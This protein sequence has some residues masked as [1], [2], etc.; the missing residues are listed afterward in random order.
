MASLGTFGCI[1]ALRGNCLYG[2]HSR[3]LDSSSVETVQQQSFRNWKRVLFGFVVFMLPFLVQREL[4]ALRYNC[5]IGFASIAVLSAALCYRAWESTEIA[6]ATTTLVAGPV[7]SLNTRLEGLMFAFPI[8]ILSFLSHFNILPIQAA[9][10][11]PS[12][13]RIQ[14]VVTTAVLA[15]GLLMYVFGVSGYLCFRSKIEGNILI[16]LKNENDVIVLAG[17]FGCGVTILF[18]MPLMVLPCRRNIL[19]LLDCYVEWR[20]SRHRDSQSE[21]YATERTSLVARSHSPEERVYLTGVPAAHYGST[22]AI[23]V[24][25]Y[26]AAVAAP[27]V[28][29]VWSLCGSGMAF[30]IAFILPSACFLRIQ[31]IFSGTGSSHSGAAWRVLAWTLVLTATVAAIACTC[32]TTYLLISPSPQ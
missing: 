24:V 22:I 17:R 26:I 31:Y 19:E 11:Q 3:Y 15:S 6:D 1:F 23:A 25:C 27:G 7:L 14:T 8:I 10:Q 20:S 2:A 30:A 4:H 12:R 16:N 18:A 5:Y 21:Q 28:A 29:V 13:K 9:L 32:Q